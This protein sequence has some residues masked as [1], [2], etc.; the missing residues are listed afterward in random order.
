MKW[1]DVK[2]YDVKWYDVKWYGT[3]CKGG[4]DMSDTYKDAHCNTS[5][6]SWWGMWNLSSPQPLELHRNPKSH[7][8]R[9]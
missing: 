4:V 5:N 2:W 7:S 6:P 8:L 3:A 9:V 1:Y